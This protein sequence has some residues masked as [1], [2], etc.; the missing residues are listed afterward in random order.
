MVEGGLFGLPDTSAHD[1]LQPGSNCWRREQAERATCLVDGAAYFAAF[2]DAVRQA[3][4]TVYLLGWDIDSRIRLIRDGTDDGWPATLGPF[5]NAVAARH[6]VHIYILT[7]DFSFIYAFEREWLPVFRFRNRAHRRIH[8]HLD[9]AHP[10]GG[11][12]HQ[13]V[14]VVDDALAFCGGFDLGRWRWD[15]PEHHPTDPRRVEREG[16]P[17][18][19]FHDLQMAV[20]GP[21]A[22]ALA[23][24][25][26]QRWQAATGHAP[27]RPHRAGATPWPSGAPVHW[28]DIDLGISRTLPAHA[29][30]VAV[31]EIE[32]LL[33]DGI[34]AARQALYIENQYF[35]SD[36]ITEAL[37]ERLVPPSG[38]EIVLVLPYHTG[39]WLEQHTMDILRERALVR[40]RGADHH[41]RLRVVYPVVGREAGEGGVRVALHSKLMI[42][43]D[44]L[45]QVGSANLSNRSLGLDSECNLAITTD[46]ARPQV[47]EGIAMRRDE[48]LAEHLGQSPTTVR[49]RLRA[50]GSLIR[51]LDELGGGTRTLIDLE[52][53]E[54]LVRELLPGS[55]LIDPDKPPDPQQLTRYLTGRSPRKAMRPATGAWLVLAGSLLAGLWALLAPPAGPHPVQPLEM[56]Q[57]WTEHPASSLW[58]LGG[59]G[60]AAAAGVS[61]LLLTLLLTLAFGALAGGLIALGS[62]VLATLA[63]YVVGRYLGRTRVRRLLGDGTPYLARRMARHGLRG[64]LALRLRPPGPFAMI[65]LIAGADRIP[66][67]RLL[68]G[69]PLG[70]APGVGV[71]MLL[72]AGLRATIET[73][74]PIRLSLLMGGVVIVGGLVWLLRRHGE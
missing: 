62:A 16:K 44:W 66:L 69:T 42:V 39:D 36:R 73:P 38:P 21:A 41:G 22:A 68:P 6:R 49:G 57:Q 9:D 34:A 58:A 74:D 15:T 25:A 56:I 48:L 17:Y 70:L 19:P 7:W 65:N 28:R 43:D 2:R 1:F 11:S 71:M 5:L 4:E 13:K 59:S 27:R 33:L 8:F 47:A 52:P 30:G 67:R 12:Q 29:G 23:E 24:L 60:L 45:F 54:S 64:I 61:V 3:R 63:G 50:H 51:V 26:R 40:L 31:R 32:R 55:E 46:P 37:A 20:T 72:G 10:F 35:T 18:P 53:R 14:V